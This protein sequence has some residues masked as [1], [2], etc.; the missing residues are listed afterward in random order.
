[1]MLDRAL[2]I[3]TLHFDSLQSFSKMGLPISFFQNITKYVM[4]LAFLWK[5]GRYGILHPICHEW[6]TKSLLGLGSMGTR[7]IRKK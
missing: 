3:M 2:H 4:S 6:N 7:E 5:P 1:M